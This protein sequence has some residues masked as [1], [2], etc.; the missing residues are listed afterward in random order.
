[1]SEETYRSAPPGFTRLQWDQFMDE[2][3]LV[4]EDALTG[5]EVDR[6]L[7]MIDEC[8]A[9]ENRYDPA[10]FFGPGNI[11]ERYPVF[12]E[13]IDH[14]CHVGFAYDIYGELL[15][16]HL[17][18]FFV[19]PRGGKHNKWHHDGARAVPQGVYSPELP[20]QIKIGYWL[21]DLPEPRMGNFVYLP[22]SHRV[23]DLEYYD[24]H[25]SVP[26]ERILCVKRGTLS[27]MHGDVW[28]RVEPNHSNVVRKNL[29][30]AYCPS[31]VC[32]ADRF[33]CDPG[34]LATLER[35]QRIIMRSYS[36]GY[37]RT[38]PPLEHFPLFL[39]RVTGTAADA[40][41]SEHVG[42]NRRKRL[43]QVER[44]ATEAAASSAVHYSEA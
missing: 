20:I 16:L 22:G 29:F 39:D 11:V 1:M 21:T 10:Q 41:S 38:K 7:H 5:E 19:R 27:I 40:G 3:V 44:W 35:E 31:W 32:E 12:S 25:E 15:K 43:T 28:H 6:Y 30:L 36:K 9:E 18:Q 33:Q 8:C 23:Q 37:D 17:S 4:I 13:L 14:P 34:W 26:G 42:L 2:G 24:T